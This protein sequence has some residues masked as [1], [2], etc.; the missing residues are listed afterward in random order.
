MIAS[1][2]LALYFFHFIS[3]ETAI[4]CLYI[5][6][7][8]LFVAE[9]GIVSMGMLTLNALLSLYAGYALHTGNT[10]FMGVEVGWGLLFGIAFIECG[11]IICVAWLWRKHK[12]IKTTTGT[13]SMIGQRAL[14]VDWHGT[15][16]TVNFE[17]EIWKASSLR[18]M[19]LPAQSSVTIRAINKLTLEIDI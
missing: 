4:V 14:V 2:I 19:D 11:V 7:L 18:E 13:E 10:M 15:H 3:L 1:V 9:L 8:L 5:S 12:R 17:G 16:G 6:A